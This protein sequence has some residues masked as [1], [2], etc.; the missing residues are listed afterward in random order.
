MKTETVAYVRTTSIYNDSRATKEITAL[1]KAG[2]RVVVLGWDRDGKS[3]QLCRQEIGT[4]RVDFR[5]FSALLPNGIGMKNID[6]LILWFRWVKR[7]LSEIGNLFAVHA[8]DLDAGIGAYRYCK[9]KNVRLVYDIYD[10]YVDS[11]FVPGIFR[12]LVEKAEIDIIDH[13]EIT[14]IC[15]EERKQQIAK[16][17]PQRL[18]VIHNSPDVEEVPAG[19]REYDYV[20]CG[21]L[22]KERMI[23]DILNCYPDN[24]EIIMCMAGR[25]DYAPLA[26]ELS[27]QYRNFTFFGAVPYSKVL[28]IESRAMCLSAIYDPSWRNHQLCAPN[29]YYEALAL[30]KPIIACK[31]TGIDKTIE[32]YN[33]GITIDYDV[34]EFYSALRFLKE[35]SPLCASMGARA[36]L[37][38]EQ[39]FNWKLM[40]NRL[41]CAY[42][43]LEQNTDQ[44]Q[45]DAV[46][47]GRQ[48]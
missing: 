8:C 15:T 10:Y 16:A 23:G 26:E 34:K 19:E 12:S 28:D 4:D 40:E 22:V 46:R 27:H 1:A 20:Y 45:P 13:A 7:Q 6:K 30:G 41:L 37:L 3:E 2:Y 42:E 17:H 44:N 24:R 32:Q 47:G 11:H 25:E 14:I 31:G 35:N 48:K 5:F 21:S 36:R 9:K 29:K 18:V 33:I 39:K 43:D 38:Y